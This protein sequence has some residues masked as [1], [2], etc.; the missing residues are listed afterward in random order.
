M[1]RKV[2]TKIPKSELYNITG[3]EF[4]Y[5]NTIFQ[6]NALKENRPWM[7]ERANKFL[8]TPDLFN[9]FR[10]EKRKQ[11]IRWQQRPHSWISGKESG[12][13]K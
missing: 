11:S 1:D 9:Y 3:N 7:L 6:L 5:F 13:K 12:R 4:N 8:F 10:Q 2:F